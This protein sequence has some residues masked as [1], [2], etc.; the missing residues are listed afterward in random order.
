[1]DGQ[2]VVDGEATLAEEA[3]QTRV[4]SRAHS[5]FSRPRPLVHLCETQCLSCETGSSQGLGETKGTKAEM[6]LPPVRG[7]DR[8]VRTTWGP[9][10]EP[11]PG[12]PQSKP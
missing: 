2:Q 3:T 4:W 12:L 5:R 9:R 11:T 10:A 1:M 6:P 8:A 7:T